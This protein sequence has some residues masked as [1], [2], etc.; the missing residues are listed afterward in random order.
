MW[1]TDRKGT[2]EKED[3]L[4]PGEMTVA[5]FRTMRLQR[6]RRGETPDIFRM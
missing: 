5:C 4:L 6:E 1:T 3:E 2:G